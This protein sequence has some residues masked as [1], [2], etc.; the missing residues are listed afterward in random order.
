MISDTIK[1]EIRGIV[2]DEWFLDSPEDLITYSYDG[3]LPEFMPDAVIVPGDRDEI[4]SVMK[5]AN[6]ERINIIPRAAGTNICG[7]SVARK[8]GIILAFHRL[9]RIIE[10]DPESR[11]AVVQPGV[12]NAELQKAVAAYGLMYPPDPA[13]MFVSTIGGNVALN[14]GGPRGVKYGVTRDYLLGL[15]VV[16]PSGEIIRTGGKTLKN[17]SGYDLTRLMCGSEGT[18]GIFTEIILR[19]VPLSPA[20]AT[21]QAIYADLDDAAT[22]VSAIIGAGIVP[23]TLELID[24]T[25]LDVISNYGDAQFSDKAQALLLI[26]VDGEDILVE[27][28]G[29]RIEAFCKERGAFQVERAST[30]EE[31]DRLWQA[32]RTAFGAVAS[33]RPNCIVEDATVPVKMLPAMIRKIV[34]IAEKYHIQIGVLAHAGDGNL[35]PLFMTDLRDKEEMER[36][37]KALVELVEA[38]IAMGGTLSGEH[39]IG[40][41]KDRFMS[42]E[43]SQTS[44]DLMRGI[45]KVF[46]PNNILNPGSFL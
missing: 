40:I 9:N 33:L 46:D 25:V 27:A 42:M 35:H 14:A 1:N 39:G 3:F 23:T 30:P 18:L 28:Q 7:S 45:K 15:E 32:R 26:E 2:G 29:K 4:A 16:L 17:V 13:S 43:F 21:L 44:I 31:A 41:A 19:L 20:K 38:A 8:G 34:E 10:I 11:C 6:R 22:T 37:D 36:V 5:V 24:R 12:V